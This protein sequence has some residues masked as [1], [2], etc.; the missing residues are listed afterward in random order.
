LSEIAWH[1]ECSGADIDI[2]HQLIEG[3]PHGRIETPPSL[4]TSSKWYWWGG[5]GEK[6]PIAS[7]QDSTAFSWTAGVGRKQDVESCNDREGVIATIT[8]FSGKIPRK[9]NFYRLPLH[10]GREYELE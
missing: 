4:Q 6:E 7:N 10:E 8:R 5:G 1:I 9:N 2:D 3:W